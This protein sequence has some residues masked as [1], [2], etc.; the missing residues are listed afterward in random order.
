MRGGG[1]EEECSPKAN[2]AN[3]GPVEQEP[4]VGHLLPPAHVPR[5][6]PQQLH[7]PVRVARVPQGVPHHLARA[8]VRLHQLQLDARLRHR[9]EGRGLPV[10]LRVLLPHH[11]VELVVVL[12]A[13]DE[14]DVV[15]IDLRVD[16]E[17]SFEVNAAKPV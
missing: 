15:V 13:E 10:R 5:V 3:L 16:K 12:V 1:E 8:R 11:R 14:A 6:L 2:E 9:P 17:S 7:L 4:P